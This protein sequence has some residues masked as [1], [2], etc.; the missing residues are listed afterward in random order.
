[1]E[2]TEE[3]QEQEGSNIM[4][5]DEEF[6]MLVEEIVKEG[7]ITSEQ[8]EEILAWWQRRPPINNGIAAE[9][10]FKQVSEWMRQKPEG[11]KE[12]FPGIERSHLNR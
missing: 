12:V 7:R 5:K 10:N 2:I 11:I 4:A 1:M 3:T 6:E 9:T 8:A